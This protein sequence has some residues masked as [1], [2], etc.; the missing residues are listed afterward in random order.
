MRMI[1]AQEEVRQGV[2]EFRF[3]D[4]LTQKK[5]FHLDILLLKILS[6]IVMLFL[7]GF[8]A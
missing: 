6:G 1:G 4:Y 5:S 3:P 7:L 8:L 2:Y